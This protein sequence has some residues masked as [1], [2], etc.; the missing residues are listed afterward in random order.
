MD[1]TTLDI[2]R[3]VIERATRAGV[4]LGAVESCTGGLVGAALT[5]VPGSSDAFVGALVTYSD[6]AKAS[7]AGVDPET[8]RAHGAVSAEVAAAM[9]RGGRD[10]LRADRCVA[11]TGVAGPGGGSDDK[12]VGT[13]WLALATERD[14]VR[15]RIL[16]DE[17]T[18]RA[19]VRARSVVAAL[20][21][22][23]PGYD[24][25]PVPH[26]Q[27]RRTAGADP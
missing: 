6:A 18:T 21:M 7:L 19:R 25:S 4:T 26:E 16:V 20:T 23:D 27:E 11:I 3:G 14:T 10:A 8:I 9:A 24:S 22:L 2:A 5:Q 15:V 17:P 13:V 12:P 1:D